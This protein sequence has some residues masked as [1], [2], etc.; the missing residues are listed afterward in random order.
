MGDDL[1]VPRRVMPSA[2]RLPGDLDPPGRRGP[3][4]GGA[5][6]GQGIRGPLAGKTG[7]TNDRRDS[8]FAGYSPDRV[9]VVWVGYDDN[10]PTHLS[11]A[12]AALPIWS[13][14]TAG[15]RP[16]RGYPAFVPP[17]GIITAARSGER[18][19]AT[20]LCPYRMTEVFPEWQVPAQSCRLPLLADAAA[21]LDPSL[22]PG[23]YG[24]DPYAPSGG[25]GSYSGYGYGDLEGAPARG[26]RGRG[27]ERPAARA[28]LAGDR[29]AGTRRDRG[30]DLDP[31]AHAAPRPAGT[32]PLE[33]APVPVETAR[34]SLRPALRRERSPRRWS[35]SS[36]RWNRWRAVTTIRRARSQPWHTSCDKQPR[37]GGSAA[38]QTLHRDALAVAGPGL[39][40]P[41]F[42]R[43]HP[44]P[45][46]PRR[47]ERARAV[48]KARSFRA[49]LRDRDPS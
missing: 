8:W 30:R 19:L 1:P 13:R 11:G 16:A 17:A 43:S 22:Y 29:G 37:R 39:S 2:G 40:S 38:Q 44:D 31:A 25:D 20:D 23:V 21:W 42:H 15:V 7:T 4:H 49:G 10:S 5:A 48:P 45:R 34:P 9:T 26:R 14:F 28:A 33:P 35:R 46:L 41:P 47:G 27:G 12:R 6:R 18:Q 36:R 24:E 3:R 32:A